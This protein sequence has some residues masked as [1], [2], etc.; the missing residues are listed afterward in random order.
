M[1]RVASFRDAGPNETK[2]ASP[3]GPPVLWSPST[4]KIGAAMFKKIPT[5]AFW[6]L[7]AVVAV[8]V[9][10]ACSSNGDSTSTDAMTNPG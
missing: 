5:F 8:V 10:V 6:M 3:P 7:L 4:L 9:P 1:T 2:L